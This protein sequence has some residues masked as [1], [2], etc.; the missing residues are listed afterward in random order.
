MK[1]DAG[2][3]RSARSALPHTCTPGYRRGAHA[4]TDEVLPRSAFAGRLADILLAGA[5][6]PAT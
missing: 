3:R 5:A 2:T 4:G 1:A 6:K